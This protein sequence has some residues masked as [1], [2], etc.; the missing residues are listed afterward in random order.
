VEVALSNT[1]TCKGTAIVKINPVV[2]SVSPSA[3]KSIDSGALTDMLE[4]VKLTTGAEDA[5]IFND[6]GVLLPNCFPILQGGTDGFNRA[7]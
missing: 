7:Q 2:L 3:L 4:L 6:T 5:T 1:P